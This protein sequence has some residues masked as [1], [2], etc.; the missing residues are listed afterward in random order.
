MTKRFRS[1]DPGGRYYVISPY[2]ITATSLKAAR[3]GAKK[4]SRWPQ[5]NYRAEVEDEDTLKVLARFENGK[6]VPL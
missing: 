3:A 2:D 5:S 4:R 6:E 1:P